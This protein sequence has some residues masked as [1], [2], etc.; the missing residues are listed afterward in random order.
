[1]R[2]LNRPARPVRP[3]RRTSVGPTVGSLH[4]I[5]STPPTVRDESAPRS[6]DSGRRT[7]LAPPAANSQRTRQCRANPSSDARSGAG[8]VG[9]D[10]DRLAGRRARVGGARSGCGTADGSGSGRTARATD[11]PAAVAGPDG[12]SG[13]LRIRLPCAADLHTAHPGLDAL[14]DGTAVADRGADAAAVRPAAPPAAVRTDGHATAPSTPSTP[15]SGEGCIPSPA[16]PP[17][18]TIPATASRV[19]RRPARRPGTSA[20][21]PTSVPA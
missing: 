3:P 2:P 13:P 21:S 5:A 12:R 1:M 8:G 17:R 16:P 4:D 10:P 15:C 6:A 20:A 11:R 9:G 14:G 7:L 18:R 19:G